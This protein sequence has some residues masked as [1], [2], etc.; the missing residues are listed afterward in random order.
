ME[1]LNRLNTK[2]N[3]PFQARLFYPIQKELAEDNTPNKIS[4]WPAA[5]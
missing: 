3:V 4:G 5:K 1:I 2:G